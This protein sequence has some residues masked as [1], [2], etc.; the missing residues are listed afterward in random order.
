MSAEPI[1][2][3]ALIAAARQIQARAHAPYSNFHVGAALLGTD[4]TVY[5]G[6]NVENASYPVGICAER[7][8]IARAV[9]DGA[10]T[11][12]AV[13]VATDAPEP[14]MPCGMCAQNLLEFAP[15]I[16][17]VAVDKAGNVERATL[18]EILPHGYRG[19]GLDVEDA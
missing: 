15:D 11:F 16:L 7:S 19:Q 18:R 3:A 13:A 6:V 10:R 14:V 8:A 4:G 9:T 17:V 2:E 5:L 1:D 12:R